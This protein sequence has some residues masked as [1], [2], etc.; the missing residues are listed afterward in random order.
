M[1]ISYRTNK[2]E[3]V[4]T[5]ASIAERKYGIEMA[6]KLQQRI[7]QIKAAD[8]VETMIKFKIGRCHPLH[9]NRKEQYAMDLVHP[10]RLVFEKIG[11]ITKI[12]KITEIVDYY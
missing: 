6:E 8:S 11:N 3:K 5:E 7:D 12:V 9:Q 1:D 2:L 4:C 10:Y